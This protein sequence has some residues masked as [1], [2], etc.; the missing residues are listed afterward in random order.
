MIALEKGIV[1]GADVVMKQEPVVE[2]EGYNIS[3]PGYRLVRGGRTMTAIR[4]DTHLESSDVEVGGKGDV[5]VFDIKYPSE[6]EMRLVNVYDQLRQVDRVR[7]Q[8]RPAQ[9]AKWKVIMG[10]NKILLG[11]DWNADSDRWDPECPPKQDDIFVMNLMDTFDLTDV[12]DR[13]ATHMSERN[14]EMLRSLIDFFITKAGMAVNLDIST[15][16]AT[17]SDH[18]IVCAHL[19]WDKGERVQV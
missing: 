6:R 9:T 17:S 3:H 8:G 14:G 16:L 11:G 13:E 19:R 18:A 5:Q 2:R 1:W 10:W 15:D 4:R 12:T 7:S